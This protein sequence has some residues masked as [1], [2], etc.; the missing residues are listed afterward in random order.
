M[1]VCAHVHY[2]FVCMHRMRRMLRRAVR[3]IHI[4]YSLLVR[5]ALQPDSIV[6]FFFAVVG[7]IRAILPFPIFVSDAGACTAGVASYWPGGFQ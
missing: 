2:I 6:H 7:P 5:K 4:L 1:N 3:L